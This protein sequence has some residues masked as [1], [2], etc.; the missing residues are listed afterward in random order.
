MR[1]ALIV[2]FILGL[3]ASP[4]R[5]S[6][7]A[8]PLQTYRSD[9]LG[10]AFQFPTDWKTW[11]QLATQTVMAANPADLDSITRAQK[12][13]GLLF[14]V[15]ISSFR[16]IGI[17]RPDEFASV[18]GRV[19]SSGSIVPTPIRIGGAD[20]LLVG[21][22]D[23][24]QDLT[25]RTAILSLGRRRIAL[26]RGVATLGGWGG[27]AEARFND[28]LSSL[29][30]FTPSGSDVDAL[31]VMLWQLSAGNLHD[32]AD[33]AVS[34]DGATLFVTDRSQGIWKVSANGA[35]LG[36]I[37]PAEVGAFVAVG[38]LRANLQYVADPVNHTIWAVDSDAGTA[39][40]FAG[41]EAG[42]G[43]GAFG[44]KSPERFAF[45]LRGTYVLDENEGSVRI[46]VFNRN[47]NIVTFWELPKVGTGV[48]E[49]PLISADLNGNSYVVGR[50]TAGILKIGPT[51][52]VVAREI[53]KDALG[54]ADP[55]AFLVDR[56]TNF[57]VATS[58]QGIY[59]L[60]ESG[61]LIGVIGKP[62]DESA[63]PKP[64]QLGRPTGMTLDGNGVLYVTDTGKYPQL[65]AFALDG[66]TSVSLQ[67]GTSDIGPIVLNAAVSG[68][69]T[70]AIFVHRYTFEGQAGDVVSI[71]MRHAEGGKLDT[72][73]DL[74]GAD[75]RRFATNDDA[76]SP[77]LDRT[78]S[79]IKDFRLPA[80]G[81]YT[82]RAT[83]FGR[84]AATGTGGYTLIVEKQ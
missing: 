12:P 33:V 41:G 7:Q 6:A 40:K 38:A 81:T 28:L 54:S 16:Q 43:R 10:L 51:G 68:E 34:P 47:G 17:E 66:N 18:L 60:N 52:Q 80:T 20:G 1:R 77:D 42:K 69:I 73:L 8:N 9:M 56:Y 36:I 75:G 27:G 13:A 53:G 72:Y 11:E 39:V 78:D 4:Q 44:A 23:Q 3:F 37:R 57:Y 14:S 64:G 25:T 45:G 67:A 71:T 49:A 76:K 2:L 50:N 26:V 58:D 29:S 15:T 82:I 55:R 46:Q 74:F 63:P 70:S 31:G 21:T 59:K 35:H 22:S 32:L 62:Y 19:A 5:G 61:K 24:T 84:E 65:V 48:I 30:F 79:Q 83:R